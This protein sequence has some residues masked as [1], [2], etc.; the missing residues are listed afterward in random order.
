MVDPTN[1]EAMENEKF[2]EP[3]RDTSAV[4]TIY[5]NRIL[6]TGSRFSAD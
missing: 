3:S 6:T 4:V 5:S 2:R 1:Q